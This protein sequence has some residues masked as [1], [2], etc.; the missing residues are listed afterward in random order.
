MKQEIIYFDMDGVIS[1]WELKYTELFGEVP[2]Q[3][4]DEQK[5]VLAKLGF[6]SL[7]EPVKHAINLL[8][9]YQKTHI[10]KI[11]TSAGSV[12]T[13]LVSTQKRAW[14]KKY[15]S[16]EIEVIIVTSSIEKAKYANENTTLI[17]DRDK[18][19]IPFVL[20]GGNII[21]YTIER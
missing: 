10:V 19:L 13:D 7:L 2:T 15:I 14:V 20:A 17:D 12:C 18:S 9:E 3:I 16:D 4:S 1:D 6:Y 8:N 21:K 11:L 5:T